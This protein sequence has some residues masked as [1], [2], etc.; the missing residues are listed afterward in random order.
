MLMSHQYMEIPL[1]VAAT[2]GR[3]KIVQFLLDSH[4]D[5]EATDEVCCWQPV[6]FHVSDGN[7]LPLVW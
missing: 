1:G 3:S 7:P 5:I 4:A 2:F 6:S